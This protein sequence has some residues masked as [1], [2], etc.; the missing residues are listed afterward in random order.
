VEALRL[1]PLKVLE[2]PAHHAPHVP[3]RKRSLLAWR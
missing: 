1:L 3:G 2:I